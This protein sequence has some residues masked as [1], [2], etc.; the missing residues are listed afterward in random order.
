MS[1]P[2]DVRVGLVGCEVCGA[3]FPE[4]RARRAGRVTGSRALPT[5]LT[6][7][8][9]CHRNIARRERLRQAAF[10]AVAIAVPAL[11]I[12]LPLLLLLFGW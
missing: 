3:V 12:L 5:R 6:V 2:I 7:C 4:N 11:I 8:P 10:L 1:R 9:S